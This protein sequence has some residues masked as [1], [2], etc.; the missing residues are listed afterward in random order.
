MIRPLALCGCIL[1]LAVPQA[2][3]A[4]GDLARLLNAVPEWMNTLAVI[5]VKAINES[6]RAKKEEWAKKHQSE[7]LS[8]AINIPP[9]APMVLITGIT[10]PLNVGRGHLIGMVPVPQF[11]TMKDLAEGEGGTM[12]TIAE[13]TAVLSPRRG[14]IVQLPNHIV[15][16]TSTIPRQNLARWIRFAKSNDKPVL[17]KYFQEAVAQKKDAQILLAYNMEEM[18]DPI[19]VRLE[20]MA[21][22]L[23][24][25]S[26]EGFIRMITELRG[27]TLTIKIEEKSSATLRVDFGGEIR[28]YHK[29]LQAFL[30]RM[31]D[32]YGLEIEEF[33]SA[34]CKFEKQAVVFETEL[35]DRSLRKLFSLMTMPNS[36]EVTE[37]M[38]SA[39][40]TPEKA[41]SVTASLRYFKAIDTALNDLR[42][43]V[44]GKK[45]QPD[46]IKSA[47]FY[48]TYATRIDNLS[49]I[50]V[51]PELQKFGGSISAKLRAM[52]ASLR[53]TKMQIDTYESYTNFT[54]A[55]TNGGWRSSG[56]VAMQSNLPEIRLRQAELARQLE[57]EREKLWA[58]IADDRQKIR[59]S[60]VQKYQVDFGTAK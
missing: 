36:L 54:M 41:A 1:L 9:R 26:V 19:S 18:L 14:Y 32:E 57:P 11:I 39:S 42:Q 29:P 52:A 43:Q 24:K 15:A 8:G 7:Y 33:R 21:S 44:E 58:V 37:T 12:E 38:G 45:K 13:V 59:Q 34:E 48:D 31:I 6:P 3:A 51:D 4:E 46:Y 30:L 10:D 27:V 16:G 55:Y 25:E 49:L 50:E 22:G 5:D 60:M 23:V 40:K 35:S 2:P 17:S 20:V 53:G 28:A 47:T 56:S